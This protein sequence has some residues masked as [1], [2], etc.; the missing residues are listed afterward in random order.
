MKPSINRAIIIFTT[1][2]FCFSNF[3]ISLLVTLSLIGY[4]INFYLNNVIVIS[5]QY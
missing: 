3:E 1:H 5:V 2:F 4:F